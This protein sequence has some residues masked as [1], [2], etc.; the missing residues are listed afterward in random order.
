MDINVINIIR[1]IPNKFKLNGYKQKYI[2]KIAERYFD[3]KFIYRKKIGFSSP[4]TDWI[5]N[6][7]KNYFLDNLNKIINKQSFE[8]KISS[9][10][11]KQEN[12]DFNLEY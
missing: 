10:F 4:I 5:S 9:H 3:K 12:E 11:D 8:K 2:L 1:K 6:N 7:G